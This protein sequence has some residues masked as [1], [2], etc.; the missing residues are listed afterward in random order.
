MTLNFNYILPP[1]HPISMYLTSAT[2][3]V[4]H[5][6]HTRILNVLV[7]NILVIKQYSY[8]T[9]ISRDMWIHV[10]TQ[11]FSIETGL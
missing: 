7:V 4:W 1:E 3:V 11:Q 8:M 2:N 9:R 5:L 6:I 10:W